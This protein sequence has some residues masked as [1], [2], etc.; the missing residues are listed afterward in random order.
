MYVLSELAPEGARV[1]DAAGREHQV[2]IAPQVLRHLEPGDRL[3]GELVSGGALK[4]LCA[5]PPESAVLD[6]GRR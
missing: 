2:R 6:L 4:I 5:Y 3:R 1:V